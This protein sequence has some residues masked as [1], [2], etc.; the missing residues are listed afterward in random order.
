[1]LADATPLRLSNEEIAGIISFNDALNMSEVEDVYLPLTRLLNLRVAAT[2]DLNDV[3]D[4]FLG[5]PGRKV[6]FVIGLAG[7]VAVGKSTTARLLQLLLA[8]WPNHPRVDLVTTDG[9][10]YPTAELEARKLMG[11]KGFPE[12]YDTRRLLEFL[13]DVKAGCPEVRAPVYSHLAYDI[14]PGEYQVVRDPDVLIVEGLNVLQQPTTLH[15]RQE[16]VVSDFFDFSLYIDAE[17]E[18]IE[19]W[20]IERFLAFRSTVFADERSFFHRYASLSAD[21]ALTTAQSIWATINAVNLRDNIEPTRDRAHLV[22]EK[23]PDH[24]TQALHLRR[25]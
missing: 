5:R 9:F 20:Y 2:Q 11:R 6:P 16:P 1:M 23:G 25:T 17:E 22:I 8:R 15:G 18:D 4:R 19:R 3:T 13:A 10:L 12:S 24:R 7:S 21:E 14:V